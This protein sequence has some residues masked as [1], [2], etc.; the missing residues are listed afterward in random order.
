MTAESWPLRLLG[1]ERWRP[2]LWQLVRRS[3]Q[4][5]RVPLPAPVRLTVRR[6]ALPLRRGWQA[7]SGAGRGTL[8]AAAISWVAGRQL[9]WVELMYAAATCTVALAIA[10]IY[11]VGRTTYRV[12]VE[13]HPRRIVAGDRATGRIDIRNAGTRRLR[14][15]GM[16]LPVGSAVA[17]FPVP[18]LAGHGAFEE[19]FR[20]PSVRRGV[21][22]VGPVRSVR[23]D[24]LGLV[25][26]ELVWTEALELFV[27]P[28]TVSIEGAAAGLLRDLEGRPTSNLSN[29]DVSFHTLREYTP[30][31]DRRY[32]HW[33]TSARTGTLMVR[34]FEDTRR[35]HLAVVLS[36]AVRHYSDPEEYELAVSVCGSL[37]VRSLRSEDS[38]SLVTDDGPIPAH[39]APSLLDQLA[40]LDQS[41]NGPSLVELAKSAAPCVAGASVLVLVTGSLP[42]L[43]EIRTAHAWFSSDIRVLA[44]RASLTAR[45]AYR[46]VGQLSFLV[47]S[48][49]SDL[50][51][52]MRRASSA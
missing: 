39:T 5:L 3:R 24:P 12:E 40:R 45:P 26:R 35:S 42:S 23:S 7:L 34:Q 36:G 13:L 20:V 41:L 14:P 44:V 17:S 6:V 18:A 49:L 28:R 2:H 52:L 25:R 30:G 38:L 32:V 15:V 31:D 19:L 11:T 43:Q 46:T 50:P 8:A 48:D 37:G 33:R 1:R 4:R 22:T 21:I 16:E 10:A 9:G 47:L 51:R 27:H 29:S